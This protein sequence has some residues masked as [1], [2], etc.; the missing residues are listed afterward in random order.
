MP[1]TYLCIGDTIKQ[2]HWPHEMYILVGK[3]QTINISIFYARDSGEGSAN[4]SI[5]RCP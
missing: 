1:D 3:K 4:V 5:I 2:G